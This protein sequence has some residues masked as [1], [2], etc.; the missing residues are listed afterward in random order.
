MRNKRLGIIIGVGFALLFVG[1]LTYSMLDLRKNRVEVCVT[2][3]GRSACRQASGATRN[4][5]I[6]TA[7]ENACTM[8]ASGMTD[9]MQ[10]GATEPSSIKDL[11]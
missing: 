7:T 5:A 4:E 11:P 1:I 8:L 10:C 3:G 6:R 9:S 2:F